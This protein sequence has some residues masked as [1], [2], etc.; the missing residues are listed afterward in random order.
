MKIWGKIIGGICGYLLAGYFGL[1]LGILIGHLFDRGLHIQWQRWPFHP[2]GAAQGQQAF[3]NATF[4]VMGHI[5]KADGRVSEIEIK[6]ARSVMDR[7]VLNEAQRQR[8][9]E[10]FSE[11]KKPE[12]NLEHT[13]NELIQACHGN[14]VLLR[15]FLELQGQTAMA[16]G[17]LSQAKQQILQKISKRLGF[18]PLNFVFF[19]D[20]F[21]YKPNYQQGY[22]GYQRQ[23]HHAPNSRTQLSDAYKTL[24]VAVTATDVEVKRAYRRLMSQHHPDKLISKGLPEEMLKLATEKTQAIQAAY[25]KVCVARGMK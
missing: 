15:F 21:N 5:A 25:E 10:L 2:G 3:F 17:H 19:E 13:L 18:A 4:L 14:K 11:G 20:F 7:M 8:A 24:G 9:A 12:F 16:E 1:F 22:Q 23:T 6:A